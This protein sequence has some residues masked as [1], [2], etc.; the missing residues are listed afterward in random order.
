MTLSLYGPPSSSVAALRTLAM[1]FER[2]PGNLVIEALA[3][4]R[5]RP[6][7]RGLAEILNQ[8]CIGSSGGV[9]R[10]S[11]F[12]RAATVLGSVSAMLGSHTARVSI[13]M[14]ARR[15]S[16]NRN[17]SSGAIRNSARRCPRRSAAASC[18]RSCAP[19]ADVGEAAGGDAP[20]AVIVGLD[21]GEALLG[22][23]HVEALADRLEVIAPEFRVDDERGLHVVGVG[24]QVLHDLRVDVRDRHLVT[25]PYEM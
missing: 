7:L 18:R 10:P 20:A 1:I 2:T 17:S 23:P 9:S 22:N 6:V 5:C 14:T 8:R 21:N 12:L 13:R 3:D 15:T 11:Q 4:Q 19:P 24:R 25:G 16:T